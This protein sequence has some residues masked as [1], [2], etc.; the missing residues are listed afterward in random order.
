MT[1]HVSR[2]PTLLAEDAPEVLLQVVDQAMPVKHETAKQPNG[3]ACGACVEAAPAV[4]QVYCAAGGAVRE[5]RTP[6]AVRVGNASVFAHT[7]GVHGGAVVWPGLAR[8][9]GG[10]GK[11]TWAGR[12]CRFREREVRLIEAKRCQP[13]CLPLG[14]LAHPSQGRE[15]LRVRKALDS[16]R[17]EIVKARLSLA[18][19]ARADL[20]ACRCDPDK[21]S[22]K[23]TNI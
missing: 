19:A 20:N 2:R 15:R 3:R 11:A 13:K 23:S 8:T 16:T 4:C 7:N 1:H 10:S 14:W 22:G 12:D 18:Y 9:E 6:A 17:L 21:A 5:R